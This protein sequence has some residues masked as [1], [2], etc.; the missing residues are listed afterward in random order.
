MLFFS[1]GL[2]FITV[3]PVSFSFLEEERNLSKFFPQRGRESERFVTKKIIA[4]S[5]LVTLIKKL[6]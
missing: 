3:I 6:T 4:S 2:T 1:L 5:D